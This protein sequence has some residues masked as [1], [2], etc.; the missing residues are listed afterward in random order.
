MVYKKHGLRMIKEINRKIR[1][2]REQRIEL[3]KLLKER[4]IIRENIVR[5]QEKENEINSQIKA[6]SREVSRVKR[7]IKGE[8]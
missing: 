4:G 7:M 2:G 6:L 1:Y 8:K 5:L 3:N